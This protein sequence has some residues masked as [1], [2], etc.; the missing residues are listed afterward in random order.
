MYKIRFMFPLMGFQRFSVVAEG[1]TENEARAT[2]ERTYP[3]CRILSI[4]KVQG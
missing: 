2:L 3:S 1:M 4:E